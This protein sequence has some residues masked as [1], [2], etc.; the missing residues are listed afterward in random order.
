MYLPDPV[1][2]YDD[3]Q[4]RAQQLR[5]TLK[6]EP[7]RQVFLL[8]GTLV[9]RK[10]IYKLLEALPLL[11]SQTC[12]KLCV[13]LVGEPGSQDYQRIR[14]QISILDQTLPLQI[15]AVTEFVAEGNIQPYFHLADF[16]LAPYQKHMGM[17]AILIRA[18]AAKKPILASDYGIM[19]K[20]VHQNELGLTI[21]ATQPQEIARGITKFLEYGS[22]L[23]FNPT[24]AYEFAQ[25]NSPGAFAQTLFKYSMVG[26]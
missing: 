2:I 10:G 3:D 20:I 8:F 4:K 25:K 18:A 22:N 12:Q 14:N 16:I 7:H 15:I 19:G 11:T 21:D 6:I 24:K 26:L 5:S 23:G 9:A 17:S 1:K 13:L